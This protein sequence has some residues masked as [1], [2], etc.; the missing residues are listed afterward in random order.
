MDKEKQCII[1]EYKT[2]YGF[3]LFVIFNPDKSVIDKRFAF[4]Q[5]ESSICDGE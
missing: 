3:S 2:V 4:R 1:D 5:D